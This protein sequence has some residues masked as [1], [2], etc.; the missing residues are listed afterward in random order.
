M[1]L[2]EVITAYKE[3]TCRHQVDERAIEDIMEMLCEKTEIRKSSKN[4]YYLTSSR[5]E[6]IRDCCDQSTR[7]IDKIID[8][9][10]NIVHS[11]REVIKEWL[12]D[13]SI[14]FF[15]YFSD[16]WVADLLKTS[17]AVIHSRNSIHD[18]IEKR[19]KDIKVVDLKDYQDLP[20]LFYKF[21]CSKDPDVMAYMWEY[22]T[23]AFSA[24]LISNTAG[25][26]KLTLD[27]FN[28]A[29]CLLDT[30]IRMFIKLGT[31]GKC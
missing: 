19:T 12:Q 4:E 23:S 6:E 22:G 8:T 9:Y 15:R 10:F 26:D 18:I 30:N 2:G 25:V 5:R 28:N 11:P 16:E 29:R 17:N 20:N 1:P 13:V 7:R 31:V 21:I 24:K 27:V 3:F 14:H